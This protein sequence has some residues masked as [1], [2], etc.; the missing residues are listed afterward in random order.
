MKKL[1]CIFTVMLLLFANGV[2]ALAETQ[3][4][5][6]GAGVRWTYPV[7]LT[8]LKS[9]YLILVNAD[10]LL[11]ETYKPVKPME[12]KGIK[13]TSS[14]RWYLEEVAGLA[15]KEMFAAALNVKEYDYEYTDK[16][17]TQVFKT[18]TFSKG[19]TLYLESAYRSYG[20]QK[21]SYYNRLQKNNG[22]DDG[23]V[24]KPGASEHQTG[25]CCDILDYSYRDKAMNEGFANTPEAQWMKENCAQ[26]GFIL[27]YPKEKE[28]ITGIKYE[29]WHF[30]YVG[31]EAAKYMMSNNLCLEEFTIEYTKALEDFYQNGGNEEMQLK[32]EVLQLFVPPESEIL[33]IYD[34][35][36]DPE[37]SMI[38]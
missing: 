8:A 5:T 25:L 38:F 29:P 21:T 32:I 15:L 3:Q 12:M 11:D 2:F 30:R 26:F 31:Q 23:Y 1:A 20:T 33:E 35:T 19:M 7:S 13:L 17:G 18:A 4:A 24:A 37:I 6:N 27:R 34:E 16:N 36:G 14:N 28:D 9:P 10:N 22:V